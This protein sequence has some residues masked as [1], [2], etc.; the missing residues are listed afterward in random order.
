M[1]EAREKAEE[2]V[3]MEKMLAEVCREGGE[4]GALTWPLY[5]AARVH[6]G[7]GLSTLGPG[8]GGV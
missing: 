5:G 4:A 8:G 2:V 3:R 7:L 6:D 1:D